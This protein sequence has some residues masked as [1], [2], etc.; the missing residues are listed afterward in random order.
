MQ[1]TVGSGIGLRGGKYYAHKYKCG[2]PTTTSFFA[3]NAK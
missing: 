1:V 2:T 3:N